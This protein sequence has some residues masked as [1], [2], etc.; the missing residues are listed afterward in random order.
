MLGCVFQGVERTWSCPH[1]EEAIMKSEINLEKAVEAFLQ[2]LTA[3]GKS[4]RTLYT[5]GKDCEQF[6]TFW[7]K[8]QQYFTRARGQI[9]PIGGL[10][11]DPRKRQSSNAQNGRQDPGCFPYA[12]HLGART[13]VSRKPPAA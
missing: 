5:Y 3:Q 2:G 7:E 13:R 9:L 4:P 10:V 12:A 8:A 1:H 11:A 6:L